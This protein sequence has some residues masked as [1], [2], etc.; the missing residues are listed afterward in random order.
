MRGPVNF[1][2]LRIMQ[3][4]EFQ[5]SLEKKRAYIHF[6]MIFLS[7]LIPTLFSVFKKIN[8]NLSFQFSI[9]TGLLAV[10]FYFYFKA[11][12]LER[13]LET[14]KNSNNDRNLKVS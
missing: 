6:T 14:I 10:I 3:Q 13:Q 8:M 7:L 12:S 2:K 1:D 11:Q 9:Y 4:I 5:K